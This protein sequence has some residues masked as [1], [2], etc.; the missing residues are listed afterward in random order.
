M[1]SFIFY[2]QCHKCKNKIEAQFPDQLDTALMIEVKKNNYE[3][4][5]KECHIKIDEGE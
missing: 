4:R 3:F 2:Y 5:C 1:N